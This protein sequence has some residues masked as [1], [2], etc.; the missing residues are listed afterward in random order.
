VSLGLTL[1][2][3]DKRATKAAKKVAPGLKLE[4]TETF[5]VSLIRAGGLD[6]ASADAIKADWETNHRFK[7]MFAS[8]AEKI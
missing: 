6:V 4:C 8:F 5:I 3:D 1:C 2:I 7:L